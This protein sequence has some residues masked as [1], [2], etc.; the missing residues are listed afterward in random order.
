SLPARSGAL[1]PMASAGEG[2]VDDLLP[3]LALA[4]ALTA[5]HEVQQDD[6][7]SDAEAEP[8]EEQPLEKR[9]RR[10]RKKKNIETCA[11]AQLLEDKD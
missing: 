10:Q 4:A 9:T 7:L 5:L 1:Y 3:E 8:D 11:W 6:F 2:G